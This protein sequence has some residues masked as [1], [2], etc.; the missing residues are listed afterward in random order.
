LVGV[1]D[2]WEALGERYLVIE[3]PDGSHTRIP[4]AW[5]DDGEGQPPVLRHVTSRFS[6]VSARAL[7]EQ[8]AAVKDRAQ[9]R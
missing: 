3:L 8:V 2:F 7:L 9:A 5:A 6:V 1:V 4:I